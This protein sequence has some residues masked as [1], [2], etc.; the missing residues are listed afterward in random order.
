MEAIV[1]YMETFNT[2]S[3]LGQWACA[4]LVECIYHL[5]PFITADNDDADRRKAITALLSIKSLMEN[6]SITQG[7]ARR[8]QKSLQ[9]IFSAVERCDPSPRN[10]ADDSRSLQQRPSPSGSD[11][12]LQRS[13]DADA[14]KGT[15]GAGSFQN[16]TSTTFAHSST[17]DLLTQ[18]EL[19][20]ANK[21]DAFDML[22][23]PSSFDIFDQTSQIS[24]P[25][26]QM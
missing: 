10:N 16:S 11:A 17:S 3:Q 25:F 5:V 9:H 21:E 13:G 26:F 20:S 19:R 23:W 15:V 7:S 1:V 4:V 14:S 18:L 8:A 2:Y 12:Q 6:M 22:F 24:D